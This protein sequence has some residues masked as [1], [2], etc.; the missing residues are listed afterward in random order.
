MSHSDLDHTRD[1]ASP[2][3]SITAADAHAWPFVVG[4]HATVTPPKE[5]KMEDLVKK[6]LR[7]ALEGR[8]NVEKTAGEAEVSTKPLEAAVEPK[9]PLKIDPGYKAASD[10][11]GVDLLDGNFAVKIFDDAE[12]DEAIRAF[13]PSFNPDYVIQ[14]EAATSILKAWELKDRV[15]VYGPTGSG[16]STLVEQLCALTRR[17]FVRVNASGDMDSSQV[18]GQLTA[19]EGSTYWVDGVV[20]EAVK[21][22]AVLAIDEW[23]V[24]P[25]EIAMGMQWLLE[26][27]S[28]LFLKEK[29]GASSDKFVIPHIANRIVFLGNTQGQ[30]DDTG[31]HA[32]TN[33]HNTATLDRFGTVVRLGYLDEKHEVRML[34]KKGTITK[35][36]ASKLVKFAS[37]IRQGY[38]TG[39]LSL[40]LSPRSMLGITSKLAFGYTLKQACDTQFLLKLSESQ[41]RIAEELARKVYGTDWV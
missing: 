28:K 19:R 4:P 9:K 24:M 3:D 25:P 10:I 23:E 29:P 35:A 12:F 8:K 16:K 33:V 38:T 15:M 20:T 26:D 37:L 17:P 30:G 34:T 18:F 5:D 7:E 11:L 13:I 32:G 14:V 36:K 27:N 21:Y 40:T 31:H 22:G 6:A 39:Q 1:D 2:D 41:Q